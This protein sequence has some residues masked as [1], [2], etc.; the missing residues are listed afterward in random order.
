MK[1]LLTVFV[2]SLALFIVA[3]IWYYLLYKILVFVNATDLMWFLYWVYLPI[4]FLC[5]A[6][7][8]VIDN[9]ED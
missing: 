3:P 5:T 1:V 9:L 7:S 6:L 4:G 8:K 2:G